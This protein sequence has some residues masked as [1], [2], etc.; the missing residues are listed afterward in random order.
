MNAS[1]ENN[2]SGRTH[3]RAQF[4]P[5]MFDDSVDFGHAMAPSRLDGPDRLLLRLN[6]LKQPF[7]H[8]MVQMRREVKVGQL[9]NAK[10]C[11]AGFDHGMAAIA[12]EPSGRLTLH[13]LSVDVEMPVRTGAGD[14][15]MM[16][17]IRHRLRSAGT[18]QIGWRGASIELEGATCVPVTRGSATGPVR[19]ARSYPS[20]IR[21]TT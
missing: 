1:K 4:A 15:G 16:S 3:Y 12:P 2:P 17:Q 14:A 9:T 6:V 18:R 8:A 11:N 21:S 20:A 10:A 5:E 19:T 13:R 7:D